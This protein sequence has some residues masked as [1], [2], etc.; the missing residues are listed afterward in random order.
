MDGLNPGWGLN[1]LLFF[2]LLA[3]SLWR[4]EG[5][6]P[7]SGFPHVAGERLILESPLGA[8]FPSLNSDQCPA[9]LLWSIHSWFQLVSFW[10]YDL[11]P[12]A[13]RKFPGNARVLPTQPFP[14][15][16]LGD[17]YCPTPETH[18]ILPVGL[19][20]RRSFPGYDGAR[21]VE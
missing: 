8:H 6:P 7:H 4:Q 18:L 21:A 13:H 2:L 15:H 19:R 3:W 14:T 5:E 17:C 20:G 1:I 16:S 12:F 10:C 9:G 11:Y